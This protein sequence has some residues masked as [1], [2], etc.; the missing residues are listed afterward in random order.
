MKKETNEKVKSNNIKIDIIP[1][2]IDD[3][4]KYIEKDDKIENSG[5][6]G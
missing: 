1:N 2:D 4:G 5:K 3:L 6:K